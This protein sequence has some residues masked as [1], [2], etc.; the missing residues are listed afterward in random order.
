M[1]QSGIL[2]T[3]HK[4][5]FNGVLMLICFLDQPEEGGISRLPSPGIYAVEEINIFNAS[6]AL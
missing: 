6:F 4:A 2:K 3:T 1:I 5:Y